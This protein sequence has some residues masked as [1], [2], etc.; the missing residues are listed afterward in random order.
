MGD[1]QFLDIIFLAMVAAFV[2]FRL[3]GVL[4]RRTGQE[5]QR[6]EGVQEGP[7]AKDNVVRL[8]DKNASDKDPETG[9]ELW[10]DS[11]P[12]GSG[13]A[14]IKIRDND[15]DPNR[16]LEGSRLAY[17]M[18]VD[19]F[20]KENLDELGHLVTDQVLENFSA[21]IAKRSERGETLESSI[22]SIDKFD[23]VEAR[24]RDE[25]AEITVKFTSQMVTVTRDSKGQPIPGQ[26]FGE[27]EVTD[28]WTF[29]RNIHSPNPNW[30]LSETRSEN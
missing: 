17:E 15:F 1:G 24:L 23:I 20:A 10:A 27:R 13:L 6:G 25:I 12:I 21:A 16:F 19:S 5:R 29:E 26:V 11:S 9:A 30:Y 2:F 14:E 4:G 8:P 22:V 7:E 3:R 28:I 18:I